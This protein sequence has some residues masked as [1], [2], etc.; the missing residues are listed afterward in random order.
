[1]AA[2]LSPGL[3]A[4]LAEAG[5][6]RRIRRHERVI[7]EGFHHGS[8]L[9]VLSGSFRVCA[10]TPEGEVLLA[11]RTRG[12]LIGDFS[13]IADRPAMASVEAR[14]ECEVV[15]VDVRVFLEIVRAR[16]AVAFELL[17]RTVAMLDQVERRAIERLTT[18]APARIAA[19]LL[20]WV[21][22]DDVVHLTQDEL[23]S[24]CGA[25]RGTVVSA[26]SGLRAAAVIT[27]GRGRITVRDRD[28]LSARADPDA[29]Q[30]PTIA[31]PMNSA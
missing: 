26:L 11:I 21:G 6:R 30:A 8:V 5:H 7:H 17:Q 19:E 23:A 2:E 22:E 3:I 10:N 27:T 16:P 31:S 29:Q 24:L 25:T 9:I 14:E 28:A 18:P 4:A 1:M 20:R 12:E 15:L 13:S